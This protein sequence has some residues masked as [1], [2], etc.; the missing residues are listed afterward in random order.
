MSFTLN[1]KD[2]SEKDTE[3]LPHIILYS[4]GSRKDVLYS[5]TENCILI[6]TTYS[7]KEVLQGKRFSGMTVLD[8]SVDADWVVDVKSKIIKGE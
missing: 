8:S 2:T 1:L 4:L 6:N 3:V 5:E 7:S